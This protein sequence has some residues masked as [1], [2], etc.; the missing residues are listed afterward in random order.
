MDGDGAADM[1]GVGPADMDGEGEGVMDAVGEGACCGT[2]VGSVPGGKKPGGCFPTSSSGGIADACRKV[3]CRAGRACTPTAAAGE[4]MAAAAAAAARVAAAPRATM[5]ENVMVGSA[6]K[7][8]R[9]GGTRSSERSRAREVEGSAGPSRATAFGQKCGAARRDE[10][11][12]RPPPSVGT[13][14]SS[15]QQAGGCGEETADGHRVGRL[16]PFLPARLDHRAQ[17]A[18]HRIR[19][20]VLGPPEPSAGPPSSQSAPL[21]SGRRAD[22]SSGGNVAQCLSTRQARVGWAPA[23]EFP[24]CAL[25]TTSRGR[26]AGVEEPTYG[27]APPERGR[28]IGT[29]GE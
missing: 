14:T 12:R 1:D 25:P 7:G 24:P 10:R 13:A 26:Y 22:R 4:A 18:D 20:G 8:E 15:R 29:G 28:P 11:R 23:T 3:E 2:G 16:G 19:R 17:V 5:P 6:G 21:A 9:K 27:K